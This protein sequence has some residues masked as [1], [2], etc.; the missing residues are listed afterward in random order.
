VDAMSDRV[1]IYFYLQKN[2]ERGTEN[3][4][5][6]NSILQQQKLIKTHRY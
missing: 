6:N 5:D 3:H 1:F 2:Q 4:E